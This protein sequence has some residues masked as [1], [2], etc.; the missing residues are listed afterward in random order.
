MSSLSYCIQI[1]GQAYKSNINYINV[2]QNR[3]LRII[4]K[5]NR[6]KNI[7]YIYKKLNILKFN[8]L[9]KVYMLNY[10]YNAFHNKLPNIVQVKYVN[11]YSRYNFRN[12]KLFHIKMSKLNTK[13]NLFCKM[14][15]IIYVLQSNLIRML[16]RIMYFK[17]LNLYIYMY[18]CV[19]NYI[20]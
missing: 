10:M 15:F 14:Y 5:I 17:E 13:I 7:D 8:D 2:L 19:Y 9:K 6:F 1:W 11:K 18:I 4:Y 12:D 16:K 3:A 20:S